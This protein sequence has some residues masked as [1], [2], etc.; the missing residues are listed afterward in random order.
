M[1]LEIKMCKLCRK[2]IK[3]YSVGGLC[4]DC[5]RTLEEDLIKIKDYVAE[6]KVPGNLTTLSEATGVSQRSIRYLLKERRL[7]LVV[8]GVTDG[9]V[10]CE[11][12]KTPIREGRYCAKCSDM[13]VDTVKRTAPPLK[14]EKPAEPDEA[15]RKREEAAKRIQIKK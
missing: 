1:P 6:K 12:C 5:E 13:F 4:L 3:E 10:L 8:E 11:I 14:K 2:P 7:E 9:L 15:T